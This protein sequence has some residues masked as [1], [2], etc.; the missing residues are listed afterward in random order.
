MEKLTFHT[1]SLG[2]IASEVAFAGE[3][4]DWLDELL[5]YLT[6]NR[7]FLVEYVKENLPSVRVSVPDATFLAWL[8]FSDLIES[9]KV[10]MPLQKFFMEKSKVAFNEGA[11]FGDGG[12][13]FIRLNALRLRIQ[14]LMNR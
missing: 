3:C 5:V 7:D 2:H 11:S 10:E 14:N 13:G 4:D 12:E 1:N 9:G 6:K 8:D